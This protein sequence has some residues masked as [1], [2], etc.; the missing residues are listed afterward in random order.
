MVVMG[1]VQDS[2]QH[3]FGQRTLGYGGWRIGGLLDMPG[4]YNIVCIT[5]IMRK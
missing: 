3:D 4:M 5:Y 2:A 1:L